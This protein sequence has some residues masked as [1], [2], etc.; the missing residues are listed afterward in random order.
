MWLGTRVR[1]SMIDPEAPD[2]T[3]AP[4]GADAMQLLEGVYAPEK[5]A[6][7]SSSGT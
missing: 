5:K 1:D 4:I 3:L 7:H 6:R 2:P